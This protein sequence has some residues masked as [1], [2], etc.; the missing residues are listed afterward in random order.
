MKVGFK[1]LFLDPINH[2]LHD[3]RSVGITL[4]V[5]TALSL[6]I[7]NWGDFG[8]QY[9]SIWN[10][11][12]S[13]VPEHHVHIG[14]LDLPNSPLL[15]INDG[16]MALF[17]FLAG[18]EIKREMLQGE[19]ASIKQSL[20][21][22]IG[23]I[24]GMIVPAILFSLINKG[25]ENVRGWAIPTATDIAFTLGVAALLGKRIPTGLKVFL[26]AL[27]IIDD[28]GAIIVIAIFYGGELQFVYLLGSIVL[29]GLIY[30]LNYNSRES[31]T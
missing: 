23:A 24:G 26:T 7:T 19:L 22:V 5:C 12:F 20:L 8:A 1:K 27:A 18:M 11:S 14:G 17:F 6:I 25:T 16:F 2:F 13:G 10:Y 15:W 3:S 31:Q 9:L 21:P 28:L 29:I 30:F 4:L